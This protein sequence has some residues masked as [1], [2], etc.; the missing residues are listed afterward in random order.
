MLDSFR[1]SIGNSGYRRA[2]EAVAHQHH[3]AQVLSQQNLSD[4]IYEGIESD[5]CVQEVRS[6]T[7]PGV[8]WREYAMTLAAQPIR[9]ALPAPAAVPRAV[10]EYEGLVSN[11]LHS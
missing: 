8:A 4:V 3:I 6:V 2:P 9:D 1:H 11:V 5:V 7:H 10:R